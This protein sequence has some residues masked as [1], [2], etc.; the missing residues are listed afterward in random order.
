M[1]TH[2]ST[3][4]AVNVSADTVITDAPT[5]K[6]NLSFIS[7]LLFAAAFFL[8]S[9]SDLK[10]DL[11]V[12]STTEIV[13]HPQGWKTPSDSANFHGFAIRNNNWDMRSCRTCH[14]GD[15][16]GG[17]VGVSCTTCH[18][19]PSGPE[20][21]TTCHGGGTNNIAPP[22][23]LS[24]NT[25]STARGVGAHT[26]HLQGT[27]LLSGLTV[28]CGE[29]HVV[30]GHVYDFGHLDASTPGRAEVDMG[31]YYASTVGPSYDP[32]TNTCNNTFC[33]GNWSLKRSSS[34]YQFAYI[35]TVMKGAS[36][37]PQWTHGSSDVACGTCHANPPTGHNT[38]TI[39]Q[40]VNCHAGV[41]DNTGKIVDKTKHINGKV[42]VFGTEY[43][44]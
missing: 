20:N 12:A 37:S 5:M 1:P 24:G 29:C 28:A 3:A 25:A 8:S 43:G 11:P 4:T 10:N 2:E 21:C 27:G 6:K 7:I 13:V 44:F 33:H 34:P 31:W 38:Y 32:Q 42:N 22:T 26:K 19:Q 17:T 41:I 9:C 39:T 16:A 18:T 35:D 30:P 14:G 15:Y 23:D 36:F 40:C